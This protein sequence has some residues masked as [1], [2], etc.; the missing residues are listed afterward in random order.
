MVAADTTSRPRIAMPADQLAERP[1]RH[2]RADRHLQPIEPPLRLAHRLHQL[3]E[4]DPLL[5]ELEL[6]A[7]QPV[8]VHLAPG[9]LVRWIVHT[10]P[11]QEGGD[12]LALGP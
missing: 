9:L 10:T 3:L 1:V 8:D 5:G 2:C 6:L 12:L 4:Y 11:Q 7:H